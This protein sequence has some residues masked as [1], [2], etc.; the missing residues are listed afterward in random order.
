MDRGHLINQR[1]SEKLSF[2]QLCFFIFIFL[3]LLLLDTAVKVS[4]RGM[5]F[6]FQLG[7]GRVGGGVKGG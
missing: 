2:A 1:T 7:E 5:I 3:H 4:S 6:S